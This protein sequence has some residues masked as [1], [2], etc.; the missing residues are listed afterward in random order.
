MRIGVA[1]SAEMDAPSVL[2]LARAADNSGVSQLW[3]TEDYFERGAFSLAGAALA[4]TIQLTVAIGV[5]NP[6]TRHPI[7]TAMEVVA[8]SEIG[9][10]RVILGL[11]TSNKMWMEQQLGIRFE[12]PLS[13]LEDTVS[14]IRAALAGETV[15]REWGGRALDVKLGA[16]PDRPVPIAM[17]VKSE[18]AL[19][20]A[21]KNA[22]LVLL[23]LGAS[24][25]YVTWV[26]SLIGAGPPVAVLVAA[27]IAEDRMDAIDQLRPYVAHFLGIHGDH[28]ISHAV[29]VDA[30]LAGQFQNGW[31][32]REPRTD[33]ASDD[34]VTRMC[35][36][37]NGADIVAG[38]AAFE[39]VGVETLIIRVDSVGHFHKLAEYLG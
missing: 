24:P 38:I 37:G 8:L 22:D 6:W 36:A 33:L 32:S 13:R 34:L 7:L 10:G 21:R 5:V 1:P 30:G 4:S 35:L 28:P 20:S 14:I 25:N 11:G 39:D 31:R 16:T 15:A 3:I 17:G 26:K 9:P 29:G 2:E 12:K 19:R 18:T 23:S 27:A